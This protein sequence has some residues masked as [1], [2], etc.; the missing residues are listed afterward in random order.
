LEVIIFA[1]L[2]CVVLLLLLKLSFSPGRTGG[3]QLLRNKKIG[4]KVNPLPP[5]Y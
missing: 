2:F 1:P 3:F 5:I 4:G